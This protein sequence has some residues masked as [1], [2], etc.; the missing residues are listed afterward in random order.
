[1]SLPQS[2]AA[3]VLEEQGKP[4]V[5]K[6][7]SLPVPSAH[8]VLIKIISCGVCR[9]DL[10]IIDGELLQPKLPLILGHEIV[11][12]V[13]QTGDKITNLKTGD[14]AGVPWLGYK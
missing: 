1:M 9:T 11:G 14:V 6:T 7:L 3:M 8:Q 2:M 4:F 13:V 10:H 5:M 12:V